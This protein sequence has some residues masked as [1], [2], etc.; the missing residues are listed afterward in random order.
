MRKKHPAE[1]SPVAVA[2]HSLAVQARI[3]H[4]LSSSPAVLYSFEATGSNNPIFVSENLTKVFGYEPRE[5]LEDRNFVPARVH[6]EDAS[7]L[8]RGFAQLFKAGH[9]INEYRFRCKDG[10]YRW[11]SDE[12]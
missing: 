9:L 11:V 10:S 2:A 1:V 6:P 8:A 3:N 5:Y 4:I 7:G 12:L